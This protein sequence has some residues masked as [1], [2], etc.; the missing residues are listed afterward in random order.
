[1]LFNVF[2]NDLDTGIECTLSKLA[3]DTKLGGPVDSLR[4]REALQ[5]DTDSLKS[6]ATTNHMKFNRTKCWIFYLDRVILV[7]HTNLGLRSWRAAP[8]KEV[9]GVGLMA[10]SI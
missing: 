10:S 9:W 6:W 7:I 2:I 8:S 1:M 4:G 5:N 3:A